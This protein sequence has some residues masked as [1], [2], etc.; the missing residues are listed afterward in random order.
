MSKKTSVMKTY[1]ITAVRTEV[2]GTKQW[3]GIHEGLDPDDACYRY[4]SFWRTV[5]RII[6]IEEAVWIQDER[7]WRSKYSCAFLDEWMDN[8]R[9]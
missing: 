8:E 3:F 6:R 4:C 9:T 2:N 5:E 7:A 1:F